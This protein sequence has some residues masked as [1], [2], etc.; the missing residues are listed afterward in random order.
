MS[1]AGMET[2]DLPLKKETTDDD[3]DDHTVAPPVQR[4]KQWGEKKKQTSIIN[5]SA[6]QSEYPGA[7]TVSTLLPW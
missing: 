5:L 4:R 3:G 2:A 6:L 1:P 7:T